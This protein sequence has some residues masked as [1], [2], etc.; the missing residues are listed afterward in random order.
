MSYSSQISTENADMNDICPQLSSESLLVFAGDWW[1]FLP[2]QDVLNICSWPALDGSL[3]WLYLTQTVTIPA[4]GK[5][6]MTLA[7]HYPWWLFRGEP[8]SLICFTL[9]ICK[10]RDTKRAKKKL[11]H[12]CIKLRRAKLV[13]PQ[14]FCVAITLIPLMRNPGHREVSKCNQSHRVS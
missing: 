13:V 8:V 3:Q 4:G 9:W 10:A 6:P 14:G 5:L 1:P 11:F 2:H 12:T 7:I